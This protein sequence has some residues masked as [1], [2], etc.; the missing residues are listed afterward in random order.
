MRKQFDE[1][2]R[3]VNQVPELDFGS[4]LGE[5]IQM[6]VARS[7]WQADLDSGRTSLS[8]S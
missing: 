8:Q 7:V 1:Q 6:C 3:F 4:S 2:L 5:L